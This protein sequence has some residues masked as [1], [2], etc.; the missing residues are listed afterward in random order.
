MGSGT[1]V[2]C[3]NRKKDKHIAKMINKKETRL[4]IGSLY[5]DLDNTAGKENQIN[6]FLTYL[7]DSRVNVLCLQGF[8]KYSVIR[9]FI[10]KLSKIITN[11]YTNMQ[12][13]YAPE[14]NIKHNDDNIDSISSTWSSSG[15]YEDNSLDCL[16]ISTFPILKHAKYKI[17]NSLDLS[18]SPKYIIISNIIYEDILISIYTMTLQEDM[19]GIKN[20]MIRKSQIEQLSE[21]IINN[22][23]DI[24]KDEIMNKINQGIHIFSG[25]L[26]INEIENDKPTN[27]YTNVFRKMR[28]IDTYR[29][30]CNKKDKKNSSDD[31]TNI[32]GFRTSYITVYADGI[33]SKQTEN[34]TI[35]KITNY[36]YNHH[37]LII[38]NSGIKKLND[39]DNFAIE[40][41]FLI[42]K[43]TNESHIVNDE[44]NKTTEL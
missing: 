24:E 35:D 14:I 29:Y 22:K 12:L 6:D 36:L 15:N 23:E 33:I 43:K 10:N 37:G 26:N 30:V 18:N 28:F 40:T 11:K 38:V 2:C 27:E 20:M 7:V 9:E 42:N 41:A 39:F 17:T 34:I 3:V 1:S 19:T 13:F 25:N 44:N 8:S 32:S 21:I 31:A 5:M 4:V 16:V